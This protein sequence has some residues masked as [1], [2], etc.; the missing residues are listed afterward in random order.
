MEDLAVGAPVAAEVEQNAFVAL[1]S[2]LESC[3]EVG[4]GLRRIGI[5][6]AAGSNDDS[7]RGCVAF[8]GDLQAASASKAARAKNQTVF[9]WRASSSLFS[10]PQCAT[11]NHRTV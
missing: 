1:G 6:R 5:D 10:L 7:A 4:P 8:G 11:A 3:R 2:G 9:K